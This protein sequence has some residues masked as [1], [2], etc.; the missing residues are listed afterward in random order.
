MHTGEAV[1]LVASARHTPTD[2]EAW[3]AFERVQRLGGRVHRRRMSARAR[4]AGEVIRAFAEGR[5]C[6]AGV[7]WGKDSVVLA[8]LVRV[9]APDVPLVWVR[10]DP[11]D[12][13]DCAAVRDLFLQRFPGPY[14]EVE[15]EGPPLQDGHLP[16]GARRPGY[17]IAQARWGDHLSGVR[18]DESSTRELRMRT[19][20]LISKHTSAPLGRWSA[21]DVFRYLI[22]HD[23][24]IHP[25]YAMSRGGLLDFA[26]LR[27]ASLGGTRG[28]GMGR[29]EWEWAYYSDHM[30]A[31]G[32]RRRAHHV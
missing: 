6:F 1:S 27:V 14:H 30:R 19:H 13:P 28:T 4:R 5:R 21:E 22:A 25:A 3:A 12:N 2:L 20:G 7:S 8:H 31:L 29:R 23:L 26:Q 17:A 9:H 24:P 15:T 32:I 10:L 11:Y 16:T 18:G